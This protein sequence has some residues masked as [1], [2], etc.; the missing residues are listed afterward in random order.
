MPALSLPALPESGD[1]WG[2]AGGRCSRSPAVPSPCGQPSPPLI[3]P[4]QGGEVPLHTRSS[5]ER[6]A[7]VRGGCVISAFSSPS[8]ERVVWPA[9]SSAGL[10]EQKGTK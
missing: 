1:L 9:L 7:A 5:E 10:R 4:A 3:H 2:C 6:A 8:P